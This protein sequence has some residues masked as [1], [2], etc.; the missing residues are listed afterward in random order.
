MGS[1]RSNRA[2]D[3]QTDTNGHA[4]RNRFDNTANI[5]IVTALAI[6]GLTLAGTPCIAVANEPYVLGDAMSQ[7]PCE[8]MS[9]LRRSMR[10][11]LHGY[12]TME[13]YLLA[14]ATERKAALES[15]EDARQ[16][17]GERISD[18]ESQRLDTLTQEVTTCTPDA[19]N[20][21]A[22]EAGN[23]AEQAKQRIADEDARAEQERKERLAAQVKSAQELIAATAVRAAGTTQGDHISNGMPDGSGCFVRPTDS[24]FDYYNAIHDAAMESV[25]GHDNQAY[26]SCTQAVGHVVRCAADQGIWDMSPDDMYAYLST[27][28]KWAM[29]SDGSNGASADEIC[30]PGD[31]ITW[32]GGIGHDCLYVGHDAVHAVDPS[33]NCNVYEASYTGGLYPGL[34]TYGSLNGMHVFRY[35]GAPNQVQAAIDRGL[36]PDITNADVA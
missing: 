6:G 20:G 28:D 2:N 36:V 30:Q 32:L 24:R 9:C 35:V 16:A 12:G 5:A 4:K 25:T 17:I 34:S 23:V 21:M 10:P 29:V 1:R 14:S 15:I 8:T 19:A 7:A 26:A 22:I 31:V 13:D 27:S 18:D 11:D 3:R 33:S